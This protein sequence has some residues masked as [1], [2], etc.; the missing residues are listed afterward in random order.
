MF[1]KLLPALADASML[2]VWLPMP[3]FLPKPRLPLKSGR[4]DFFF[5]ANEVS[6]IFLVFT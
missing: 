1:W 2:S 3:M 4:E 6:N 5:T